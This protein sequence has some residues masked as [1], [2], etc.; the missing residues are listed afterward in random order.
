MEFMNNCPVE[1]TLNLIGGKYKA[2]I[3]WHL[4]SGK[5]RFS[6]LKQVVSATLAAQAQID[7]AEG[8]AVS[9]IS[10][11]EM[12]KNALIQKAQINQNE[13]VAA[14]NASVAEFMAMV[15][16]YNDYPDTFCYYKYLNTLAKVY[17]NQRLYIVGDGIDEGYLFF[18]DGVII[19]QKNQT[20][21]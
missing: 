12:Q 4:S 6:Q 16:A 17:K 18:G 11:A 1:A 20:G 13:Q 3:L 8:M 15:G 9:K 10:F 19:Y 5:L 21:G 7:N 14:A 2:L